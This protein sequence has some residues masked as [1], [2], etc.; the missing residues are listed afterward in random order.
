MQ[1]IKV[2]F[3]VIFYNL[4]ILNSKTFQTLKA[5]SGLLFQDLKDKE[6]VRIFSLLLEFKADVNSQDM[7][8]QTLLHR[9]K[10]NIIFR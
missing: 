2:E 8:K 7:R 4:S 1:K 6:C 5:I 10:E 9:G 3:Q